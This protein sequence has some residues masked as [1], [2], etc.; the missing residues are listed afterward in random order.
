MMKPAD[1]T[2]SSRYYTDPAIFAQERD[3]I[4]LKSWIYAGH[5]SQASQPGD[6]LTVDI[7]DQG[8]MIVRGHD[9]ALRAFHNVCQHR[10]HRLV[11]GRGRSPVITCPYHAW[12][13]ALDGGLRTARGSEKV[14]GFRP[15]EFGLKPVQVEDFLGFLFVNLDLDA[16]PFAEQYSGLADEIHAFAPWLDELIP[17]NE[18]RAAYEDDADLA[19]NWKVLLDNCVECYHCTPGHPAFVDLIDI[20]TYRIKLHPMHTT[21]TGVACKP[22]NKAYDYAPDAAVKGI[23]FWHIWPNLTFGMFPGSEN[24]V[25]FV[26]DP[27][28]PEQTRSRGDRFVLPGPESAYDKARQ[29]YGTN[30]LW[31]EDK[32]ICEAVQRGLRSRGYTRGRFI[33]NDERHDLTEHAAAFFQQKVLAALEA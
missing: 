4:F 9:G 10:G 24:F 17:L 12:A 1:W 7:I 11:E 2:L 14:P 21:H 5:A 18:A 28:G 3:R 15:E 23:V 25:A 26:I 13:Y 22:R 27:V 31:P 30:T 8:A 33:L 20:E 29:A 32:G 16:T 6:Y 19:C